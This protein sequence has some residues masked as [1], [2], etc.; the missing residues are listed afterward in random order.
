MN[1]L[2]YYYR[3]LKTIIPLLLLT[4][5]LP[6]NA[7]TVRYSSDKEVEM[8]LQMNQPPV[9]VVFEIVAGKNALQWAAPLLKRYVKLLKA[10][11]PKIKLAVVSHGSEQFALTKSN[12]KAFRQV[13]KEVKQLVLDSD[14]PVH[15]CETHA[16]WRG[17]QASDFPE[18]VSV[19]HQGPQE[20]KNYQEFGYK[21]I[22]LRR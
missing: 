15:V 6:L 12:Q 2:Y 16:S 7:S 3:E 19:S 18:Y 4:L 9:G 5:A 20:I 8:I 22:V 21:L 11:H 14:V 10:K 17:V 13:H 1:K